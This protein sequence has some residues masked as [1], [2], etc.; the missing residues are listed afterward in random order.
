MFFDKKDMK[1]CEGCGRKIEKNYSFCP[2]CGNSFTDPEKEKQEYGMLGKNDFI[3]PD[4]HNQFD[5]GFGITDKIFTSVFNSLMKNL[6]KQFQNQFREMEKEMD[7]TEIKTFPN[8]IRIKIA[9][10]GN[11]VKK[12]KEQNPKKT[13]TQS[14]IKKIT[15][16][17]KA[18]AKT[19]VKRL[20][21]KVIYELSTPGVTSQEDIFI[22]KLESGYEIKAIGEKKIYVN[23]LPI[24]LPLQRYAIEKNKILVEFLA[25]EK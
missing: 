8:G 1:K 19:N 23:N 20:N 4:M 7:N 15:S 22:S 9:T 5:Q 11:H 13:I 25:Q 3:E 24:N 17:P 12:T 16:L 2:H 6:D 10:P 18:Q 21:N 14:Q